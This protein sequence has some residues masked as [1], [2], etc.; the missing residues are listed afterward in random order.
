MLFF[1]LFYFC[2]Y[3]NLALNI[4]VT[5]SIV[6]DV[7]RNLEILY[8]MK[9]FDVFFDT[10]VTQYFYNNSIFPSIFIFVELVRLAVNTRLQ[11]DCRFLIWKPDILHKCILHIYSRAHSNYRCCIHCMMKD[12]IAADIYQE[13]R[14]DDRAESVCRFRNK[15]DT[16]TRAHASTPGVGWWRNGLERIMVADSRRED[17]DKGWLADIID[18]GGSLR[19]RKRSMGPGG[20]YPKVSGPS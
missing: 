3:V 8:K 9:F 13:K 5:K 17:P 11:L 7:R 15:G 4:I 19:S 18:D 10:S 1:F 12:I 14:I 2:A 6:Y 20:P 16:E